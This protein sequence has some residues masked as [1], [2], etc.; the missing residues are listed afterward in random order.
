MLSEATGTPDG[1]LYAVARGARYCA[2]Q[3]LKTLTL[4][5]T[6]NLTFVWYASWMELINLLPEDRQLLVYQSVMNYALWGV[7]PDLQG[8]QLIVFTAIRSQLDYAQRKG[9]PKSEVKRR[10]A[11]A[12]WDKVAGKKAAEAAEHSRNPEHPESETP[13]VEM[14]PVAEAETAA[15]PAAGAEAETEAEVELEMET[16]SGAEMEAATE[17][18]VELLEAE[19]VSPEEIEERQQ[20][21]AAGVRRDA[22]EEV[23]Q[24]WNS[25][26]TAFPKVQVVNATRRKRIGARLREIGGGR[27]ALEKLGG[28]IDRMME[29]D[30]LRGRNKAG[31]KASFDW[32]MENSSN[33]VKVVEGNYSNPAPQ[34]FAN[35][36]FTNNNNHTYGNGNGNSEES[37][38]QL[39]ARR[40][41]Y[42]SIFG[43][44]AADAAGIGTAPRSRADAEAAARQAEFARHIYEKL[45]G[46]EPEPIDVSKLY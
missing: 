9:N 17:P 28:I 35:N 3:L 18:E 34:Q 13:A 2:K 15:A 36:N 6:N 43:Q 39:K 31:W 41:A 45:Y 38:A 23:R 42:A 10:A 8:D 22:C 21:R 40:A 1:A 26:A 30:F 24:L 16:E 27:Q 11:R 5:N 33:W 7:K 25:R 37:Q 12:R 32:L 20:R 19:E 44:H 4:M 46:P 29:S 14:A